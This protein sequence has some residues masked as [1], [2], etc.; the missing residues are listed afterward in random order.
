MNCDRIVN[1]GFY[2]YWCSELEEYKRVRVLKTV[3]R[4]SPTFTEIFFIDQGE[5]QTIIN[6]HSSLFHLSPEF[7]KLPAQAI[8]AKLYGKNSFSFQ[9]KF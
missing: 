8:R 9:M 2:V 5:V 4:D 3:G 6:K 1:G 7:A